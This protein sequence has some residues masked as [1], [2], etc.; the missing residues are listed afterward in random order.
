MAMKHKLQIGDLVR[1]QDPKDPDRQVGIIIAIS[2]RMA[3]VVSHGSANVVQV[4]WPII[5][6]TDWEY[7]FFLLKIEEVILTEENE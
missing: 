2:P 7:D 5:K 3:H 4:Y 1:F 6:E